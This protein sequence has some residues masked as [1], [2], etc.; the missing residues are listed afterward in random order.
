[1]KVPPA[2]KYTL[3]RVGL[4]ALAFAALLP[5]RMDPLLS[6]LI[7]LAISAVM[8]WFLLARWRNEMGATI[9]KSMAARKAEKEKLRAALAGDDDPSGPAPTR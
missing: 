2:T 8:S 1:M 5:L 7:A 6:L 9:E 3:A 4:F